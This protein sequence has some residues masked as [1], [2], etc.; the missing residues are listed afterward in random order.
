[1]SS[2][3]EHFMR[4]CFQL[5]KKGINQVAPNP[6]VGSVLTVPD[7]RLPLGERIIGEGYHRKLGG[8]H[9]E[10][11]AVESVTDKELLKQATAYVSLEPCS[12]FGKTPP[13]AHLLID[14]GVK[15]V[16]VACLDPNPRVAGRGVAL[17]QEAGIEV[18]VNVLQTEALLINRRFITYHTKKRPYVLL[19]WAETLDGFI[20]DA[21]GK[22]KW[23][24]NPLSR[25]YVH[26]FRS[27][28]ASI[29]VGSQTAL[30]D[31]PQLNTRDWA[32]NSPTRIVL[33]GRNRMPQSAYL[34]NGEVPTW[35]F[36]SRKEEARENL[37]FIKHNPRDLH[38]VMEVLYQR[39]INSILV[40]GGKALLQSFIDQ[41]L[42][43]EA[44]VF[45][46]DN[47]F[48]VGTKAPVLPQQEYSTLSIHTN[49]LKTYLRQNRAI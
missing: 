9:A 30:N 29:M 21:S 41:N 44:R 40:E 26:Q 36:T 25:Q 38:G 35:V 11:H 10:V 22:P 33:D 27:E 13:C 4:R 20:A 34:L 16:V 12:H 32:G 47:A 39:N 48:S 5:A 28:E 1:M 42:W 23:I 8:P 14:A 7:D 37:E 18:L 3:S 19:K 49:Q 43:D 24:S 45:V 31:N 15:K 46:G 17:L 2:T 6:M